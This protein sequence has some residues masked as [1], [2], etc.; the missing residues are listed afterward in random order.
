MGIQRQQG[1]GVRIHC[2]R[3]LRWANSCAM[4][5]NATCVEERSRSGKV[6]GNML[7]S[8]RNPFCLA[9]A[10]VISKDESLVFS[11]GPARRNSKLIAPER[12]S[13]LVVGPESVRSCVQGA[14]PEELVRV[15]V[16][17]VCAR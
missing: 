17:H 9:Q 15:P 1:I 14:V 6:R 5:W 11:Y 16:E 12:G 7:H 2:H 10:F 3:T 8:S 4:I 13:R